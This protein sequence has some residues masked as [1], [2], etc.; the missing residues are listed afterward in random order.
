MCELGRTIP[1]E[2]ALQLFARETSL[3]T[4]DLRVLSNCTG[5]LFASRPREF[6]PLARGRG[7]RSCGDM[8][9]T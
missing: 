8:H 5:D 7:A 1:A 3:E 2:N 9:S 6:Q 4:Q